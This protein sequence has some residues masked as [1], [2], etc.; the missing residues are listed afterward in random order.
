[1]NCFPVTITKL[2]SIYKN[3]Q[4]LSTKEDTIHNDWPLN[5]KLRGMQGRRREKSINQ[6]WPRTDTIIRI[7][8]NIKTVITTVFHIFKELGRDM[9]DFV[10]SQTEL[11]ELKLQYMR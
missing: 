7:F 1:M 3:T 9:Q 11:T 4:K 5:Q 2:K 10:H 6:N 8:N